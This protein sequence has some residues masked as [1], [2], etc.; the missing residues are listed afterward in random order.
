[1]SIAGVSGY[2]K[3]KSLCYVQSDSLVRFIA[4]QSR[5]ARTVILGVIQINGISNESPAI[6]YS[7]ISALK[8]L[9]KSCQIWASVNAA[10]QSSK[11]L[12]ECILTT[13]SATNARRRL[14]EGRG[15]TKLLSEPEFKA[16][17]QA[18]KLSFKYILP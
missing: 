2:Q 17:P 3:V 4:Q 1:M 7:H 14:P 5:Q 9:A 12:H 13:L 8:S 6:C 15:D 10:V 16:E 11:A 18:Q